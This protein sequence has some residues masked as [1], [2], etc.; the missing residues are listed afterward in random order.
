M[1]QV[2]SF[3]R[4]QAESQ[5]ADAQEDSVHDAMIVDIFESEDKDRDGFISHS[6]FNGPKHDEF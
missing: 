5:G 6:E 2:S 3:I 1:L 4:H